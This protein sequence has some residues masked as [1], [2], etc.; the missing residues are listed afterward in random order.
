MA[1]REVLVD[2]ASEVL[3]RVDDTKVVITVCECVI[4]DDAVHAVA[5]G[6]GTG[7]VFGLVLLTDTVPVVVEHRM[8]D[9]LKELEAGR[10]VLLP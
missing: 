7:R 6:T 10:K 4:N 8:V 2:V 3:W 9:L 1:S 5:T